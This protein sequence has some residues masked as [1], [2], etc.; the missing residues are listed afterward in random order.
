MVSAIKYAKQAITTGTPTTT[1]YLLPK[2]TALSSYFD[3]SSKGENVLTGYVD[4]TGQYARDTFM[5][6]INTQRMEIEAELQREIAKIFQSAT[7]LA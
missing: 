1:P 7:R 3:R 2:K 4:D 6:D 5:T